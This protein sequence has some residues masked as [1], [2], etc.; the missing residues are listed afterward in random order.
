[1]I[2]KGRFTINLAANLSYFAFS[3][4]IGLWLT[5]YLIRNLGV[6]AYG[7]IPLAGN[8]VQ[9]M[10]LFTVALNSMVGRFITIA[11]EHGRTEEAKRIFNTAFWGNVIIVIF[12]VILCIPAVIFL[13]KIFVVPSGMLQ[14]VRILVLGAF[15]AFFCTLLTSSFSVA[16]FCCNRFGSSN[17]V[18]VVHDSSIFE[19][20]VSF[21]IFWQKP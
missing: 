10:G 14:Q 11:I 17:P 13:N 12:L 6:A 16:T 8:L 5:P 1:M 19:S 20:R 4:L 21:H 3:I 2:K 18:S 9:Y 15:G 7:F